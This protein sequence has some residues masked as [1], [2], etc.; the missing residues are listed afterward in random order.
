[1]QRGRIVCEGIC[2]LEL[3]ANVIRVQYGDLGYL[4]QTL[5]PVCQDVAKG[6]DVHTEMA[7]VGLDLSNG[8]RAIIVEQIRASRRLGNDRIWEE[9]FKDLLHSDFFFNGTATT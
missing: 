9:R 4:S 5:W 8:L 2:V 7:I 3:R 6:T 1:M